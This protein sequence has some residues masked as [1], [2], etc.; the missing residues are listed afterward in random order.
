[1]AA[2][3][4]LCIFCNKRKHRPAVPRTCVDFP[5]FTPQKSFSGLKYRDFYD[6]IQ[7]F[8]SNMVNDDQAPIWHSTVC[9][10]GIE[11]G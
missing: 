3:A 6:I 7:L 1:M 4:N 2:A 11:S 5:L 10:A 9:N 8:E